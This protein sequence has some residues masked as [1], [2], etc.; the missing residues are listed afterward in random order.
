MIALASKKT[1]ELLIVVIT[2]IASCVYLLLPGTHGGKT[3]K[4]AT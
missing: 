2:V 3:S 1:E 4:L